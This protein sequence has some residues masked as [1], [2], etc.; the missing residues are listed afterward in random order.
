MAE[1]SYSNPPRRLRERS[2]SYLKTSVS[3]YLQFES[4]SLRQGVWLVTCWKGAPP[5]SRLSPK[6]R[7]AVVRLPLR[8][9]VA[10]AQFEVQLQHVD[11][12]LAHQPIH[13]GIRVSLNGSLNFVMDLD[14][15]AL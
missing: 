10:F 5:F 15:V 3:G 6:I 14:R 2:V 9:P 1:G 12:L 8:A 11:D 13:R 4:S 7:P